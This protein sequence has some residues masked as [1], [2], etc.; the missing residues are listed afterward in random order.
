MPTVGLL[1]VDV[2]AENL[3]RGVDLDGTD[4]IAVDLPPAD[5]TDL[6]AAAVD[7]ASRGVDPVETSAADLP[8]GALAPW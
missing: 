8:L 1:D 5:L 6:E 2:P 7:L 4:P 3:W